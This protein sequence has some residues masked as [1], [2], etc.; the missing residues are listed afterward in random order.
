MRGKIGPNKWTQQLIGRA[1][2]TYSFAF[3]L[4]RSN[5][6]RHDEL[7]LGIGGH[8]GPDRGPKDG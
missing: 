4:E 8:V 3:R 7:D 6:H 1:I 2:I 5:T